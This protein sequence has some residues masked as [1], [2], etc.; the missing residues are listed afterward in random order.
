[1]EKSFGVT[2]GIATCDTCGWSTENYKNARRVAAK[3]A[4]DKGHMV[5]CEVAYV[6]RY[7]GR[8]KP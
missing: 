8:G 3:H 5:T 2:H 7:D 4:K 1:M 6:Y